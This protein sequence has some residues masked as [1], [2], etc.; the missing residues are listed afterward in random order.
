[1]LFASI[2]LAHQQLARQFK[3]RDEQDKATK[4]WDKADK[5]L[6]ESLE[7]LPSKVDLDDAKNW[8]IRVHVKRVQGSLFKEQGKTKEKEALTAYNDA[9]YRLKNAWSKLPP[10]DTTTD[11]PI[12]EFIP[13]NNLNKAKR[14]Y[15]P[16]AT[17]VSRSPDFLEDR[18]GYLFS[19]AATCGL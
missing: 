4:E 7:Q 14:G 12:Q 18:T 3:E 6:K 8:A 1:M 19:R 2:S 13:A 9:F 10:V 17:M 5:K 16:S 11:I 15:L